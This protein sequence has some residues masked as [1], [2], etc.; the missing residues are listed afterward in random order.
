MELQ[1]LWQGNLLVRTP[2]TFDMSKDLSWA[3]KGHG[4]LTSRPIPEVEFSVFSGKE[5]MP[6]NADFKKRKD[7]LIWSHLWSNVFS[8][9]YRGSCRAKGDFTWVRFLTSWICCTV[10]YTW[11]PALFHAVIVRIMQI[12]ESKHS[13]ILI[14]RNPS[15]L[16]FI[17]KEKKMPSFTCWVSFLV[18][19]KRRTWSA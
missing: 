6:H 11:F 10:L 13:K 16:G 4:F 12:I 18:Q 5:A 7:F 15:V 3:V 1:G 19:T 17:Q 9:L 8:R 2:E 14:Y